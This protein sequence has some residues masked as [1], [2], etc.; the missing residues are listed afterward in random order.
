MLLLLLPDYGLTGETHGRLKLKTIHTALGT[1]RDAPADAA[2]FFDAGKEI[3]FYTF[4]QGRIN[5][6]M[7]RVGE[8]ICILVS[9]MPPEE[10]LALARSGTQPAVLK[11]EP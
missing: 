2:I 1:E 11:V 5:R 10:L 7:Q 6:V 8:R 9:E 3:N 4:S